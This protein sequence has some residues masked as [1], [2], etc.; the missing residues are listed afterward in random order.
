MKFFV[1]AS[2]H[3]YEWAELPKYDQANIFA[4]LECGEAISYPDARR[5]LH[6]SPLPR[7]TNASLMLR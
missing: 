5:P 3:V 2:R 6:P 1:S 4:G 7:S